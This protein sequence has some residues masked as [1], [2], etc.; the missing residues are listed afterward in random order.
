MAIVE[1]DEWH[2]AGQGNWRAFR[3]IGFDLARVEAASQNWAKALQGI[4][5]PW[6]CWNIDEEWC[7]V[8]QKL[9]K[10]VGWTPVV[11]FDPRV[12]PPRRTVDSAIVVNFNEGLD[13]P[14]L[15]PHFPMEFVFRFCDRLAFW[16]SDLLLR[17]DLMGKLANQFAQIQDGETIATYEDQGLRHIFTKSRRR[18]WE[19]V[20]CT[21]RAASLS[22]FQS[23]CGWWMSFK[24][25]PNCPSEEERAKRGAYFWDHGAGIYYWHK[26]CSGRVTLLRDT[27]IHEGH[28]T[29]IGNP[30]Y[31][32]TFPPDTSDAQRMMSKE[33]TQSFNLSNACKMLGLSGLFQDQSGVVE[34]GSR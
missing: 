5:R 18:Y 29:K 15:Y 28:F 7:L 25:H 8:Q 27:A 13:L 9:I 30:A 1:Q 17:Q 34:L 24:D 21:T 23:G 26:K 14:V 12:G 3:H 16:H 32:R 33:L 31:R 6:L 11:G 20:G 10:S 4:A 2:K 22:Q 19:L